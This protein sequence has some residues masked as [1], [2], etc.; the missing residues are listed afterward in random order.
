M[1]LSHFLRFRSRNESLPYTEAAHRDVRTTI[2]QELKALYEAPR[3]L[4]HEMTTLLMHPEPRRNRIEDAKRF[5][6]RTQRSGGTSARGEHISRVVSQVRV[7]W[8]Q[9]AFRAQNGNNELGTEG[10]FGWG[11]FA[12]RSGDG[13]AF[14]N[15][16]QVHRNGQRSAAEVGQPLNSCL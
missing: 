16:E 15:D 11:K 2:G 6:I 14:G 8:M 9:F 3:D 12:R 4:P 5:I 13:G 1:A 10:K 7:R